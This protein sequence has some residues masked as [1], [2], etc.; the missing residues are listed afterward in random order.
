V[1]RTVLGQFA[2]RPPCDACFATGKVP[3]AAGPSCKGAGKKRGDRDGSTACL[4][5][6]ETWVRP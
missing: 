4:A 5:L 3:K 6:S 1:Q 2:R